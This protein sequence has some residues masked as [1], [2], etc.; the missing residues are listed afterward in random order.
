MTSTRKSVEESVFLLVSSAPSVQ[1]TKEVAELT[2]NVQIPDRNA[3][4]ELAIFGG[5]PPLSKISIEPK[6]EAA[7][8]ALLI[9]D[10]TQSACIQD[11]IQEV[12]PAPRAPP[13]AIVNPSIGPAKVQ[14]QPIANP[15]HFEK[16]IRCP[17]IPVSNPMDVQDRVCPDWMNT[18]AFSSH[19]SPGGHPDRPS[20]PTSRMSLNETALNARL[21]RQIL[22]NVVLF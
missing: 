12:V 7:S 16:E 21:S 5:L 4:S 9:S 13:E 8:R 17:K 14:P 22:D 19:P 10:S 20:T 11:Q 15:P 6:T 1:A 3:G 18:P 2:S